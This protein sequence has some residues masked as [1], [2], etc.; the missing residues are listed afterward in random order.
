VDVRAEE[1]EKLSLENLGPTIP[2]LFTDEYLR[3]ERVGV[4]ASF[5]M[6]WTGK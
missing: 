6:I 2:D 3:G 5:T 4:I 1:V